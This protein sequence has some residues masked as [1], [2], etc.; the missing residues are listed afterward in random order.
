MSTN[1]Q[2][3]WLT[4]ILLG[5]WLAL[6]FAGCTVT[7]KQVHSSRP[8]LDGNA[9]TSGVYADPANP[10]KAATTPAGDLVVSPHWR[11]RYNGLVLVY[12][13]QFKPP[14][15]VDAGIKPATNLWAVDR[16]HFRYFETMNRWRKEG[17][18]PAK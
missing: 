7:P 8:S 4:G 10:D 15:I 17:R 13:G 3:K 9:E 14:L 1:R 12:G 11:D 6:F 5:S 2:I 18:P 16:Q